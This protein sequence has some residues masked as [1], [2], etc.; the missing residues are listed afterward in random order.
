MAKPKTMPQKY[1]VSIYDDPTR[2]GSL[3]IAFVPKISSRLQASGPSSEFIVSVRWIGNELAFEWKKPHTLD[4]E[5]R[6]ELEDIAR[7]RM[8]ARHEWLERLNQLMS[9]VKGWAEELDWATKVVEKKMEDSEVGN[10]KAPGLLL[11]METTRLFLEPI[12]RSAPGT[13]GV[14][15]FCLMP[16]Y[17]DVAS[18][19]FYNNR[20]NVHYL[21]E[22]GPTVRN[23]IETPAKPFTK[24]TI[25][26]VFDE[27]KTHAG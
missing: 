7:N 6:R 23:I 25:R 24:A 4:E 11:Q 3:R 20:W 19:Y 26:R 12:A 17:D 8:T 14:V 10:Y 16:S 15:D 1:M 18:L 13:E 2:D 27:M 5:V 9:K 21:F 22:G